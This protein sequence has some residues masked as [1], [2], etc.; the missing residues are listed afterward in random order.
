MPE[1][2]LNRRVKVSQTK[3]GGLEEKKSFP[4]QEQRPRGELQHGVCAV[5]Q[6]A[7]AR[8]TE[9]PGAE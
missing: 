8:T 9:F 1:P 2:S 3:T 5:Q 7:V 4:V 6:F